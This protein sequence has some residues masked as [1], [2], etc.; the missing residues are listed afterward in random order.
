MLGHCV[1]VKNS[2]LPLH[3]DVIVVVVEGRE[4]VLQ[5]VGGVGE[6]DEGE[7]AAVHPVRV[8]HPLRQHGVLNL[9]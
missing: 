6:E 7:E 1:N 4:G 9:Q 5:D 3:G 2:S 8:V